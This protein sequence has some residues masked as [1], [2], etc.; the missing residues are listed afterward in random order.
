[1]QRRMHPASAL[2]MRVRTHSEMKRA[3]IPKGC[4]MGSKVTKMVPKGTQVD[5][6]RCKMEVKT[7]KQS[8]IGPPLRK[9]RKNRSLFDPVL[10]NNPLKMQS[11]NRQ[12]INHEKVWT[13]VRKGLQNGTEIDATTHRKSMQQRVQQMKGNSPG[14]RPMA[15][16]ILHQ[17][18]LCR[19]F[20]Y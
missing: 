17:L 10:V 1:M 8:T 9:K 15:C 3:R 19:F 16:Q 4:Q 13:N 12:K 18:L 20:P 5:W 6:R 7:A 14:Q 11:T 2:R